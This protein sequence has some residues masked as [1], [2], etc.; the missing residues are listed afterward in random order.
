MASEAGRYIGGVRV[1]NGMVEI[2]LEKKEYILK[3]RN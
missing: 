2:N 1:V 3:P